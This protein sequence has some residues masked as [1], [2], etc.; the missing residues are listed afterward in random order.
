[1]G[2]CKRCCT[3]SWCPW[4]A[5]PKTDGQKPPGCYTRWR[6]TISF[7]VLLAVAFGIIYFSL[8]NG[9]RHPREHCYAAQLAESA[10]LGGAILLGLLIFFGLS[11]WYV[12]SCVGSSW[13]TQLG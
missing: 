4:C 10:M 3:C 11:L 13:P 9:K 12:V 6:G 1:M 2:F 5:E 7:L 8:K